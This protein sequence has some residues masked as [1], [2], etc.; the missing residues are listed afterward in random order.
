[1][2]GALYVMKWDPEEKQTNWK[3]SKIQISANEDLVG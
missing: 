3:V 1:M 2:I